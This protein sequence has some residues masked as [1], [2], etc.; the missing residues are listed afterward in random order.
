MDTFSKS[1]PLMR[2]WFITDDKSHVFIRESETIMD[3]NDPT[4]AR[5]ETSLSLLCRSDLNREFKIEVKDWEQSGNYKFI[6]KVNTSIAWLLNN[7]N[8]ELEL[9]DENNKTSGYLKCHDIKLIKPEF[10]DFLIGG[11]QINILAAIDFTASNGD[12]TESHSLHCLD[13]SKNQY[14]ITLQTVADVLLDYDYDKKISLFGFGG[15]PN[16]PNLRKYDTDHCFNLTGNPNEAEVAG[17]QGII[18]TYQEALKNV[19]LCGPTYF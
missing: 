19:T 3:N 16:F 17:M 6:G 12:Y 13:L 7:P 14:L 5:Y 8:S 9:H 15:V 18:S 1:D 10:V 11:Q 2:L 4:W